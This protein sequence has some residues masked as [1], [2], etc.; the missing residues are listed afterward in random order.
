[1]TV[2]ASLSLVVMFAI[3]RSSQLHR[4]APKGYGKTRQIWVTYP[5]MAGLGHVHYWT[6]AVLT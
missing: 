1:M 5:P 3:P 2:P 4:D 6:A